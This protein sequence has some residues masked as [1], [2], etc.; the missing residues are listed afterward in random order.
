VDGKDVIGDC[1]NWIQLR[2]DKLPYHAFM[3]RGSV[4]HEAQCFVASIIRVKQSASQER[5]KQF[6]VMNELRGL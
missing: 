6:P 4:M 1:S 5:R 3:S 2:P